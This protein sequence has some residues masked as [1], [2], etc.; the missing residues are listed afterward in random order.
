M[1]K[2]YIALI[3]GIF[4]IGSLSTINYLN[5]IS[6]RVLVSSDNSPNADFHFDTYFCTQFKP[7][8]GEW[9]EVDC[10]H[11]TFMNA[12]GSMIEGI[13]NGSQTTNLNTTYLALGNG[14]APSA[15]D[16]TLSNEQTI[17]GLT[18]VMG[19]PYH[20]GQ[21]WWEVNTT[22]TFTCSAS[23]L[24]NTTAAFNQLTAGTEFAGG[25]ITVVTFT[26]NGDQLR[27]RHNYTVTG[28]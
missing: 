12:G 22:F 23:L 16:T 25:T 13:L 9:G 27:L 26:T 5:G 10:K 11:N 6:D 17:C 28:S 19:T 3:F 18:R 7:A 21:G 15:T 8:A 20:L 24:V 4:L 2:K 1:K 14:T